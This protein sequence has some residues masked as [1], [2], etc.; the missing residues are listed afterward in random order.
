MRRTLRSATLHGAMLA[1]VACEAPTGPG[2]GQPEPELERLPRALTVAERDVIQA[3]NTFAFGILRETVQRQPAPNIFLSPLSA[4]LA[5]GMTMNGARGVTLDGMRTALGFGAIELPAINQSYRDLIDL[6]LELD[7]GVDMR[8]A[9]SI[10]TRQGFP[11]HEEFLQ[12]NRSYFDARVTTLDFSAPNAASTINHWVDENTGGKIKEIVDDPIAPDVVM[13]LINAIY[14]K[15]DWRYRFDRAH[16]H[17]AQFTLADGTKKSVRMMLRVGRAM[18]H[19]DPVGRVHVLELLYARGAFAMTIVLP[20]PDVDLNALIAGLD[21]QRWQQW[22]GALTEADV[23]IALPRFRIEYE[24]VMNEPLVALGM[25]A[26]F[27]LAPG[28]DFTGM[29]PRGKDLFISRVKQ[30]TYVDVNEEGTEAAAVTSV[31]VRETSAPP[32]V[33]VDRPF[34]VALRE[35]FSGTILFLGSIGDPSQ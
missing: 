30:K 24:T 10:W 16:T 1:L 32:A 25:A 3:N 17:D 8:I 6:L 27:G 29:S 11:F 5:L 15:G 35:R 7:R 20:M 31:E 22:T 4:T 34:L 12:T 2:N 26:A 33:V 21:A 18:L 23:H 9:N 14:F 13:Y 28:T 19:Y